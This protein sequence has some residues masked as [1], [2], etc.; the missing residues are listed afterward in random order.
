MAKIALIGGGS[1]IFGTTLLND[2]LGTECLQGSTYALMGPTLSKLQK[3]E[4][5]TKRIIQKNRLSAHV[6][7]TTDQRDALKDADYVIL[8]FQI[9]G[10]EAYKSDYEIPLKYG[11]DQCLGQCVGPGGVFRAQRSIPVMANIARDMEEL[12]P[13]ALM[14][15]YVN[16]MAANSIG[17]FRSSNKIQYVGLCHGVQ[18]TM[19]L[20]AGYVGEKKE[21]IDFIAAGIN[22]M[23]WFVKLEKDGVDLYPK[24][25]ATFEKPE[26]YIN[27]KVRGEVMRHFGYFMTE[28]TGH[29]SEYLPYFRKN[30]VALDLY[31][32]QPAFGGE[33]GAYYKFCDMLARK[34]QETDYLSYES[35]DLDPRSKEYCSYVIEAL[36]TDKIFRLNGNVMNMGYITNL[37]DGCC[38][39]VP[40][41]ADRN[42]LHPVSVGNLPSQLAMLN[43]SNV[44][45]QILAAEAA[46][47]GDPEL[48]FAAV[49]A[50]PLTAAVLT[51]KEIRDMT[52]E[53]LEDQ[54]QWLPQYEGKQMRKLNIIHTP[55]GTVGATVPLDPALAIVHRFGKLA[56]N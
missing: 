43:Q 33:S 37:P 30:Q 27:D 24:L 45:V 35:G 23:A 17:V 36:E 10:M 4:A 18:T 29:L 2:L 50:D 48:L 52:T 14:M 6:Y 15:N 1:I 34:Y 39:E 22:H 46:L 28:S 8:V 7:S 47:T 21:D 20:I 26:Y 41:F 53:M 5:Y 44:S 25:R 56:G 55:A 9:G 38:V 12:C 54:R 3:V 11:V 31:C 13:N 42:G 32:D 19:D 40:A 49:A 16:P 51:L